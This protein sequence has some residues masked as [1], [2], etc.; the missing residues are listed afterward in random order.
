[1][2][3][4][5]TIAPQPT[6]PNSAREPSIQMDR[7]PAPAGAELSVVIPTYNERAN[8]D[9]L[10]LRLR[11]CLS[12]IHWE[13]IFV[14][15][16]SP[17]GTAER[18]REWALRDCRVR[19]IQRIAR[20]GLSSA[21]VEGILSSSAPLVAV[22]DGD[23][24]HDETVLPLMLQTLNAD[25]A[26]EMV[27]A[28]RY[29]SGGGVGDWAQNR[30]TVSRLATV[31]GRR[32][33]NVDLRDPMSGFFMLRRQP[34]TPVLAHLSNRGFKILVDILSSAPRPVRL[35]EL[36][37]RF[38]A[39]RSGQSKLDAMV[40]WEFLLMLLDKLLGRWV[41]T[42]FISFVLVGGFGA[43]VHMSLLSLLFRGGL[44]SFFA[45]QATATLVAMT[46]NFLFNNLL[47]YRDRRLHGWAMLR[48]W[49]SFM[50][51]CSTGAV[52]NVGAASL[53]FQQNTQWALSA[54]AG[55]LVGT[56]WN[57]TMTNLFTWK[58]GQQ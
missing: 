6:S 31:L 17:D 51:V 54:L 21:C 3:S 15:D 1:M 41:P 20:R 23:L 25:P 44:L 32:L 52:A 46:S 19:C 56:V 33:L 48:G 2:A 30:V 22:M 55:I 34:L 7:N 35:V 28:S 49:L 53:L 43:V 27:V 9:E 10:I 47:T 57:Y 12:G 58:G 38:R 29:V 40:A 5:H 24:Q 36:P 11:D 13:V 39:R 50:L 14:D 16:D 45:A 18:V 26:L 8:V 37:Y 42:R 4:A